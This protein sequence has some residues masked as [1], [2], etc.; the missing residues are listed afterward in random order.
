MK[1]PPE[2]MKWMKWIPTAFAGIIAA[3]LVRGRQIIHCE[4][5]TLSDV[6]KEKALEKIDL[7]KIDCEGAE[8]A[9]L[10][11]IQEADWQKI[12]ALVI[13]VHDVEDR[14]KNTQ[15]LLE[16]QGFEKQVVEQETGLEN[17]KMYNLFAT[18]R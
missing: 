13:E 14:L 15:Q 9:V 5:T 11:G 16:K 10:M 8:W 6:I 1:N 7:L 12:N 2:D 18:R 4:L 17:S 3:Y